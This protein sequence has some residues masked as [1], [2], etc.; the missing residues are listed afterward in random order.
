M[1]PKML[2]AER[3]T[4]VPP[5]LKKLESADSVCLHPQTVTPKFHM[6]CHI[7]ADVCG[8]GKL[9]SCFVTGRKHRITKRAALH[10]FRHIE[11]TVLA[12]DMNGVVRV[13]AA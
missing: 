11:L 13:P 5:L 2:H 12:V 10:M 6:L 8:T 4:N 7:V 1:A 3:Y 9:L